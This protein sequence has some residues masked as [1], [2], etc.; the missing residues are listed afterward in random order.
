MP[1]LLVRNAV[2]QKPSKCRPIPESFFISVPVAAQCFTPRQGI[3]V[4]F[5]RTQTNIVHPNRG[6]KMNLTQL[7]ILR[8]DKK[9]D[10]RVYV[11]YGLTEEEIRI[12]EGS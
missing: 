10:R 11:L 3:A 8:K 9:I 4:P 6:K 12:V 5:V 2:L 7:E 1:S